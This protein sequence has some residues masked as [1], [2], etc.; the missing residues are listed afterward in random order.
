[1]TTPGNA[2]AGAANAADA[3]AYQV[4]YPTA[5]S[6]ATFL[7]KHWPGKKITGAGAPSGNNVGD[8]WLNWHKTQSAKYPQYTLGQ[9]EAAFFDIVATQTLGNAVAAGASAVGQATNQAGQG[10][11]KG[12]TGLTLENFLAGFTGASLWIRIAKV[13]VGGI[14]LIVGLVKLTGLES[15]APG[16]VKTA[17]KAAPLL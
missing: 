1:M 4:A 2:A 17:V 7:N 6:F 8:Q 15:K 11:I 12:V 3:S 16:I 9:W 10:I 5:S 13:T 14:I